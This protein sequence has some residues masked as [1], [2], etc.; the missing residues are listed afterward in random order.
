M[1]DQIEDTSGEPAIKRRRRWCDREKSRMVAESLRPGAVVAEIAR[2]NQVMRGSYLI[3][4]K[5]RGKVG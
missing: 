2:R 3:G 5:Q 1:I 4:A